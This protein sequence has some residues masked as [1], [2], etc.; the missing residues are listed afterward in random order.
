[1][2]A[3]PRDIARMIKRGLQLAEAPMQITSKQPLVE[4]KGWKEMV[5]GISRPETKALVANMLENYRVERSMMDES[6]SSLTVGNFDKYAFPLIS[7]VAENMIAQD[8]VA[9]QP[10][11]GPSGNVFFLNIVTGQD[12]GNVP[13]GSKVWDARTG[14]SDRNSDSDDFVPSESI[15]AISGTTLTGAN[16]SYTPVIPGTVQIEGDDGTVALQDDANGN[17]VIPGTVT[18]KGTVDYTTGAIEVSAISATTLTDTE[19]LTVSYH[20]NTELNGEAQQLDIEIQH[21]PVYCKERK[22]RIRWSTEAAQILDALHSVNAE[23]LL[24]TAVTNNINWE[25]DR[26]I[27]EDLRRCASAGVVN[28]S[29]NIPTG[30]TIGYSEHKL[31]FVDAM[32]TASGYISRATNRVRANWMVAGMNGSNV[33]ETLPQ[34]EPTDADLTEIEGVCYLGNLGRVKVYS[35][36]HFPINECLMG[37]KGK[38]FTRAGYIYAPWLLLFSTP[39]IT[40]DD[41]INRKGMASSY[42]KKVINSRYYA[43]VKLSNLTNEFGAP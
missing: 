33:I 16:L 7:I 11:E 27:I 14:K 21:A 32:V 36:P 37:Y 42:A 4:A 38:D 12:K 40:L 29:A 28:W 1:M 43:K 5:E 39:T 23:S 13:R 24:S 22:M 34:F 17:L 3:N 15:G 18:T 26:E 35:D 6:T 9:V 31:T 2:R 10:L 19:N 41:F 30:S 25:I 20:Y 8:L